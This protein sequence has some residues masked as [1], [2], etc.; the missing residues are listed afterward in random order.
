MEILG[1][2]KRLTK[3]VGRPDILMKFAGNRKGLIGLVGL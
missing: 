3:I 2:S 1:R